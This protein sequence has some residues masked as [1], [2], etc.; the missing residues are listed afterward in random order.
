MELSH[1]HEA[2]GTGHVSVYLCKDGDS[3]FALAWSAEIEGVIK[4]E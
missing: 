4:L 1:A 2:V 3:E